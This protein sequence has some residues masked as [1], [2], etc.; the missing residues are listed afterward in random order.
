MIKSTTPRDL[1]FFKLGA[2]WKACW[3]YY[4]LSPVTASSSIGSFPPKTLW[5]RLTTSVTCVVR[6]VTCCIVPTDYELTLLLPPV[7]QHLNLRNLLP[8][9]WLRPYYRLG[10]P[11]VNSE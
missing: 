1:N 6:W 5:E 9:L 4:L 11:Y 7:E 8:A 10:Q 2:P 3:A